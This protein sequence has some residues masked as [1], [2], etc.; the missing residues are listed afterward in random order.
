MRIL[1]SLLLV[2]VVAT[3]CWAACPPTR[4]NNYIAGTVISPTEVMANENNLYQALQDGLATDCI[5]D[6]AIT[7]AKLA[8]GSVTSADIL[9]GTITS[10]DLAFSVAN[11]ILPSGA[12]F[13]MISGSCPSWSTDVSATYAAMFPRIAVTPGGTGGSST[14]THTGPSHSHTVPASSA[15]WTQISRSGF[16][17]YLAT[18]AADST[19]GTSADPATSSSGTGTT[20]ATSHDPLFVDVKA[21]RVT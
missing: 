16:N 3:P 20:G 1:S 14:H 18:T 6:N 11:Q 2:L 5:A 12:L 8:T 15:V 13:F 7:T 21:C 10:A 17:N 19:S 9:D 4:D